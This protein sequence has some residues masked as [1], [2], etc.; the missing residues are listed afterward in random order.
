MQLT[1][2]SEDIDADE[3]DASSSSAVELGAADI[4]AAASP[5][6]EL[7]ASEGTSAAEPDNADC[8]ESASDPAVAAAAARALRPASVIELASGCAATPTL[9]GEP[10]TRVCTECAPFAAAGVADVLASISGLLEAGTSL[11]R[12]SHKGATPA[13]LAL[14]AV[15][16]SAVCAARQAARWA[17][18]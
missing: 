7:S 1:S 5:A 15:R 8:V 16:M 13:G 3:A 6:A 4:R 18:L 17:E 2:L 14:W 12:S 11:P 10:L 9:N